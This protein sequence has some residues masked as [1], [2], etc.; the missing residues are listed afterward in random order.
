MGESTDPEAPTPS[1]VKASPSST[2]SKRLRRCVQSKLSWGLVKQAAGVGGGGGGGGSG[3]GA[4]AEAGPSVPT[5]EV[6]VEESAAEPEK[7]TKR[8]TPRKSQPRRKVHCHN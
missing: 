8:G 5:A 6:A 1:P 4:E 7:G 2:D 3:G